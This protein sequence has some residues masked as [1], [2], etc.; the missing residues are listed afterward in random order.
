MAETAASDSIVE[1]VYEQLKRMSVGYEFKP[2]ERLNE[3]VLAK[4]LGVSRTPLRE[5]LTRL[6][7]EGLLLFV[8]G[9][10]FFCRKLDVTEVFSLYEMRKVIEVEALR[11]SIER[12]KDEDIDALLAFLDSTGPEPGDRTVDELVRLDEIFHE[13][14]MAMS[15]NAEMLRVLQNIN[16]RIRF[17]RWIDMEQCDRTV[18]QQTHRDILIGL[19]ARNAGACVPELGRH[20]NRRLDEI[21]AA[22]KEGYAQIY[23]N[24]APA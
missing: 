19:K 18:S 13:R 1:V 20:I 2:G 17:V 3:G 9:K 22:L 8:P 23:M 4:S 7:A 15:G 16:A 14:L 5:A 24:A 21:S 10:G 6:F 11:I 12:A